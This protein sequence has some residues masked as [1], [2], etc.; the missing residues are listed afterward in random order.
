MYKELIKDFFNESGYVLN[1][2]D[3]NFSNFSY[4]SIKKNILQDNLSKGKSLEY[5][6]DNDSNENIIKF[7][8]DLIYYM[9]NIYNDKD[10]YLSSKKRLNQYNKINSLINNNDS[11]SYLNFNNF[12]LLNTNNINKI[13]NLMVN[14]AEYYPEDTIG[15]AKDLIESISKTILEKLEIQ[16]TKKDDFP[17]IINKVMES[18]NLNKKKGSEVDEITKL[19]N[20]ILGNNYQIVLNINI[21]RNNF[22]TGHGRS[23]AYNKKIEIPPR[24]AYLVINS[25]LAVSYFLIETFDNKIKN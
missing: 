12:D 15:K 22:G 17:K 7:I 16:Y 1:F 8:K 6:I 14:N 19:S 21:L 25:T 11:K 5:F 24:Y 4:N 9:D 23:N 20:K 10:L 13:Y 2:S 18:L 3:K